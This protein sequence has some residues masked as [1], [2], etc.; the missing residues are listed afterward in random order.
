MNSHRYDINNFDDTYASF[1]S[2]VAVHFNSNDHSIDDF[3]F[4]PTCID[5]INDPMKRLCKETFWIH[6][7]KTLYPLGMNA[8]VIYNA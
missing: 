6:K 8:K 1:S 2:N 4:M 3:S 5:I 7:L